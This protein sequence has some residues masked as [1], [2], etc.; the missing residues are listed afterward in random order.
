[1]GIPMPGRGYWR[2]LEIGYEV[3]KIPLP[4][5]EDMKFHNPFNNFWQSANIQISLF[6]IA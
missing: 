6:A 3:E 2:K 4:A 1:M 5:Y